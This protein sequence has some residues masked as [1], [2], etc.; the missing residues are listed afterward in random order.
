M[1]NFNITILLL[2]IVLSFSNCYKKTFHTIRIDNQTLDVIK[3]ISIGSV[4]Y[5]DVEPGN[6]TSYREIEE[7]SHTV[8]GETQDKVYLNGTVTVIG[9]GI[10]KWTIVVKRYGAVE[11]YADK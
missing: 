2:F 5:V 6:T 10:N 4:R 9:E 3:N 11:L 7:G 8:K 1:K